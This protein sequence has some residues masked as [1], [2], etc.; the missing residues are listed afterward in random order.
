MTAQHS[1]CIKAFTCTGIDRFNDISWCPLS[2]MGL[3]RIV[4]PVSEMS[5]RGVLPRNGRLSQRY[6]FVDLGLKQY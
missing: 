4:V 6:G 1:S 2:S 5:S 3:V